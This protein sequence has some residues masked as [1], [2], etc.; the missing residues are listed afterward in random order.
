[1]GLFSKDEICDCCGGAMG[2]NKFKFSDGY[3]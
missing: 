2:Y 1:M 3:A